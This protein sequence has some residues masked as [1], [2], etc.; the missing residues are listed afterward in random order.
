MKNISI[1]VPHFNGW[2]RLSELLKTIPNNSKIETIVVDDKSKDARIKLKEFQKKFPDVI[3]LENNSRKKGAG[4]ARNIGLNQAVGK[5]L[6]F[7]DSDDKF[8]NN[9]VSKVEKYINSKYDII[10][11][12]PTS[13]IEDSS[14]ESE[15]HKQYE[16]YVLEYLNNKNKYQELRLK[17]EF[18]VPWSKLIRHKIVRE[19][20]INFEEIMHSNDILFSA[21]VGY[22]AKE[23]MVTK[24]NIYKVRESKGSLTSSVNEKI[25]KERFAAWINYVTFIKENLSSE[26]F[27]LLN[28]SALP[29]LSKVYENDLGMQNYFY[30]IK[31][32]LKKE[33]PIV[34]KRILKPTLVWNLLKKKIAQKRTK[35]SK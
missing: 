22:Y 29:L 18:I 11:F 24:E 15:R 19:N 9:W 23:I 27:K 7:A 1:I 5:W 31:N 34:D 25:F 4:T 26:D 33:I 8:S 35:A 14:E 3:F 20:E 28:L 10:Y 13:F 16:H 21:K 32:S 12:N 30:V 17:Y 2:E 6:L